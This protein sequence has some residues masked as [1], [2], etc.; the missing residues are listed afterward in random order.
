MLF[1]I[2][3]LLAAALLGM[4]QAAPSTAV[5]LAR[6]D[7]KNANLTHIICQPQ[8][9]LEARADFTD[10]GIKYLRNKNT[11]DPLFGPKT[12]GKH[13]TRVSCEYASGIY[14]CNDN[15]FGVRVP[16]DTLADYAQAVR[17]DP[18]KRCNYHVKQYK[19]GKDDEDVT[20]GQA[21]DANGW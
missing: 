11:A 17:D 13:C 19:G 14:V 18:D 16:L 5:Q 4:A 6:D 20:W 8:M 3:T 10:N 15:D 7:Q 12:N 9:F 21:F 1:T 2:L